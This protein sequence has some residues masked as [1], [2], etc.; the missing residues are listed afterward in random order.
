VGGTL[1]EGRT[2][3]GLLRSDGSVTVYQATDGTEVRTLRVGPDGD[4]WSVG[5]GGLVRRSGVDLSVKW[6]AAA[7]YYGGLAVDA[8]GYSYVIAASKV[9]KY[10]ANGTLVGTPFDHGMAQPESIAVDPDGNIVILD[11]AF[12]FAG[13]QG[14][15]KFDAGGTELWQQDADGNNGRIAIDADGNIYLAKGP[16]KKL[17]PD[18]GEIWTAEEPEDVAALR[19]CVD[20]AGDA[21]AQLIGDGGPIFVAKYAAADGE[22][23]WDEHMITATEANNLSLFGDLAVADGELYSTNRWIDVEP[24]P[25]AWRLQ[26]SDG[27]VVWSKTLM[28]NLYACAVAPGV[29]PLFP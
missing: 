9:R 6:T 7:A 14:L 13:G 4:L 27:A 24:F 21:Y 29:A 8:A 12:I 25:V 16:L 10:D 20:S 15:K 22:L 3:D 23:V 28:R 11:N 1:G 18:G 2:T 17:D 26:A 19:V 5:F